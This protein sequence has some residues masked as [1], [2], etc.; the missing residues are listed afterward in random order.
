MNWR[1][2]FRH[3]Q[4]PSVKIENQDGQNTPTLHC[5]GDI[6]IIIPQIGWV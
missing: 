4:F 2:D 5:S 6:A 3:H 1:R